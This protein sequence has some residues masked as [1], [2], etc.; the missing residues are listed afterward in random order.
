MGMGRILSNAVNVEILA[1]TLTYKLVAIK[2]SLQ[3]ER[4][5]IPEAIA[6]LDQAID[7]LYSSHWFSQVSHKLY[8]RRLEGNIK[9]EQ[10]EKLRQLDVKI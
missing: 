6:G 8:L 1:L 9:F 2:Q 5:G 10:Q 4:K 3:C 7:S